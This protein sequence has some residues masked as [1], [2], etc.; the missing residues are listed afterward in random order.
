MKQTAKAVDTL[1][2][3]RSATIGG[4]LDVANTATVGG[5]LKVRGW[6][7][8]PNVRGM[9]VGLFADAEALN[10]AWPRPRNGMYALVGDSVPADVWRVEDGEWVATGGTGGDSTIDFSE[11]ET[12]KALVDAWQVENVRHITLDDFNAYPTDTD[13]IKASWTWPSRWQIL[14][15]A[16]SSYIVGICDVFF[17]ASAHT[18]VEVLTTQHT[19][20]D[21]ELQGSSHVDGLVCTYM[22]VYRC[23]TSSSLE[24]DVSTWSAWKAVNVVDL[25]TTEDDDEE[26]DDDSS[27]TTTIDNDTLLSIINSYGTLSTLIEEMQSTIEEQATS[28]ASLESTAEEQATALT[29]LQASVDELTVLSSD[30]ITT[31][32]TFDDDDEED[33]SL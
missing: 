25:R 32:C 3:G 31:V 30:D 13:A 18:I 28:I 33:D 1:A 7:D 12:Y 20:A 29:A 19:I 23:S 16:G 2:V 11:Y 10:K 14:L 22:R 4:R 17:D 5:T 15:S 8:A 26:D 6:L 21:E 27:T 24:Q 9:C